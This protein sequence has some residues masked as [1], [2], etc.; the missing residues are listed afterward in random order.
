VKTIY[1]LSGG[2]G[3]GKT[4]TRTTDPMLKLLPYLDI[5]DIY[6]TCP[7]VTAAMAWSLFE[8]ELI[9]LLEE[10]PAIVLEAYFRPGS[11]Q[12][13]RLEYIAEV[14][15]FSVQYIEPEA[16]KQ[17]RIERVK[18]QYERDA[19]TEPQRKSWHRR[20]LEARLFLI[21]AE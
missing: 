19:E 12:R 9:P 11:Y 1:A 8:E 17:I 14:N 2:S 16:D 20:Y 4:Y 7:N 6:N 13:K 3:I 18:A 21:D 10:Q 5:A 15:G